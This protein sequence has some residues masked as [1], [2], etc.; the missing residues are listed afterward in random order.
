MPF[1]KLLG[2]TL[3]CNAIAFH[4]PNTHNCRSIILYR[5]A[6]GTFVHKHL[7]WSGSSSMGFLCTGD[8]MTISGTGPIPHKPEFYFTFFQVAKT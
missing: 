4:M 2:A 5:S 7:T 6:V 3:T 8:V 1:A